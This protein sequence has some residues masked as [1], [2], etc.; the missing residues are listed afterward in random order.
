MIPCYGVLTRNAE[1]L[2]KTGQNQTDLTVSVLDVTGCAR[3]FRSPGYA[4]RLWHYFFNNN[5]ST[6][7]WHFLFVHVKGFFQTGQKTNQ[8]L[9]ISNVVADKQ[10]F[11]MKRY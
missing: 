11:A 1:W 3:S 6:L 9:E 4:G 2:V 5:V 7:R 10:P 8:S